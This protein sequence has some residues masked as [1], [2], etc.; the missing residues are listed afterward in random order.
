MKEI[1]KINIAGDE[2]TIGAEGEITKINVNGKEYTLAGSGGGVIEVDELPEQGIEYATYKLTTSTAVPEIL[3]N[4]DAYEEMCDGHVV[5]VIDD[6]IEDAF[7]NAFDKFCA[8]VNGFLV[9]DVWVINT[10]DFESSSPILVNSTEDVI[11]EQ[12]LHDKYFRYLG[13]KSVGDFVSVNI[14]KSDGGYNLGLCDNLMLINYQKSQGNLQLSGRYAVSTYDQEKG[15]DIISSYDTQTITAS[16]VYDSPIPST[17]TEEQY[18]EWLEMAEQTGNLYGII[19]TYTDPVEKVAYYY[20]INGTYIDVN[21]INGGFNRGFVKEG[22]R[23]IV[24]SQ[25]NFEIYDGSSYGSGRNKT[26]LGIMG[27]M[28]EVNCF[29]NNWGQ[30][31]LYLVIEKNQA[32]N[33]LI[34]RLA[35]R[36]DMYLMIDQPIVIYEGDVSSISD[37]SSIINALPETITFTIT[38]SNFIPNMYEVP[39][40]SPYVIYQDQNQQDTIVSVEVVYE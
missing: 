28:R 18:D 17:I 24:Q 7:L 36:E 34:A 6:A 25:G 27:F 13:K 8:D 9:E 3:T 14:I 23:F 39:S 12:F 30:S 38:E 1:S 37:T 20:Y 26:N 33:Q 29:F 15:Y 5:I 22:T 35:G 2:R 4:F 32:Q 21:T 31:W 16:I 11:G 40:D 10:S 19:V